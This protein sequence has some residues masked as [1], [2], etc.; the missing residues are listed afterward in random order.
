M[1]A[2]AVKLLSR[3]E[4]RYLQHDLIGLL[5]AMRTASP[6]AHRL[7]IEQL[8]GQESYISEE[9]AP[10]LAAVGEPAAAALKAEFPKLEES[11]RKVAILKVFQ[12][13]GKS[14]A[15]DLPWLKSVLA[16]APDKYVKNAAED[17]IEAVS[18]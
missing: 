17:A 14:A 10:A 9:A 2:A 8:V 12:L 6:E 18:K 16:E 15:K 4:D 5:G 11:Y 13:R 7:M 3:T 1:E